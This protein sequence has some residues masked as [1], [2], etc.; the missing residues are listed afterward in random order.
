M[1]GGLHFASDPEIDR[2][3][4]SNP[5]ALDAYKAFPLPGAAEAFFVNTLDRVPK[6]HG[7]NLGFVG[8]G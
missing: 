8:E 2:Q 1:S 5:R 6:H 7:S 4:Q 3:I